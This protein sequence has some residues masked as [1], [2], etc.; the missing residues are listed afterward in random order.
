MRELRHRKPL[1]HGYSS[2][3]QEGLRQLEMA[4]LPTSKEW[5]YW[6]REKSRHVEMT[7]GWERALIDAVTRLV[8]NNLTLARMIRWE[9]EAKQMI[10]YDSDGHVWG[11]GATDPAMFT[12]DALAWYLNVINPQGRFA[13]PWAQFLYKAVEGCYIQQARTGLELSGIK[14]RGYLTLNASAQ[15]PNPQAFDERF[16]EVI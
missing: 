13:P 1:S 16:G 14:R 4:S 3:V 10:R 11:E 5:A 6:W 9:N 8:R 12:K 7:Y 15:A 2:A